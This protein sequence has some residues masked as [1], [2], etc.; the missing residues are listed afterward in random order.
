MSSEGKKRKNENILMEVP[1][2][3]KYK[4]DLIEKEEKIKRTSSLPHPILLLEGHQSEVLTLKYNS[5]GT[6]LASG[7]FDKTICK[8]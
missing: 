2:T 7:S 3:K 4:T 8:N 5:S 6:I 1:N